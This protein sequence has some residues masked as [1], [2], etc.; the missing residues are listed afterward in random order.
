VNPRAGLA[1]ER[2]RAALA[3]SRPAW[4]ELE[5]RL[6]K[7]PGDA[8]ELARDAAARGCE[9][10]LSVGGDGTANE[11]AWGLLGS[12]SALGIVP[13][14]S[15]N[16]LA[17]TLRLPLRP[18]AALAALERGVT[19]RMDV[20]WIG[21]KPFLNVAGAGFDAAVGADFHAHGRRGGRRGFLTYVRL[22]LRRA[23][24]Y[25]AGSWSIDAGAERFDGRAFVIVFANGR[26][27][28][29]GAVVAP[30]ARLDDG[31]L[32]VG[33]F[34]DAP[35]LRTLLG[36]CRMFLG[37]VERLPFYRPLRVASL[38]LESPGP[39]LHHRDG[40]PEAASS[41]RLEL[42]IEPRAL[43]I[44]APAGTSADPAGPFLPAG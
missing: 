11:V 38:V 17:R 29:G 5:T 14:G 33:I 22:S 28:G 12:E 43:K 44:L 19:R 13:A 23:L 31:L 26:Q 32:D 27:Y 25:Q 3:A 20:G 1:A 2:A 37:G 42:R 4:R 34:E 15:G 21:G 39:I 24:A 40:E 8:R 18:A 9:L 35:R 30:R 7:G 36:A 16:G 41:S 10:V 6:T